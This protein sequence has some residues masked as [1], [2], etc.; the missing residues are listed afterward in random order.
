[1]AWWE[2][3]EKLHHTPLL[4]Q[5]SDGVMKKESDEWR[6]GQLFH[7]P[8]IPWGPS[9]MLTISVASLLIH[10]TTEQL[11]VNQSLHFKNPGASPLDLFWVLSLH[12]SLDMQTHFCHSSE[13][14][15]KKPERLWWIVF[16]KDNIKRCSMT[17]EETNVMRERGVE[18][19]LNEINTTSHLP[20]FGCCQ[21]V[22]D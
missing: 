3:E 8:R 14:R 21:V 2:W 11:I 9:T 12:R 22:Y 10:L 13:W 1:M 6:L 19:L 17:H 7:H 5:S 15:K 4:N 18:C 20:W 16:L